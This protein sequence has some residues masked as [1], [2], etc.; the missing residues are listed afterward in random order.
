MTAARLALA[1]GLLTFAC[2][3]HGQQ[4]ALDCSQIKSTLIPFELST[5][6]KKID[7]AGQ[8]NSLGVAQVYRNT[9]G[10]TVI[11][12]KSQD[13][14]VSKL[15]RH[16]LFALTSTSSSQSIE[17]K[18][19][20]IDLNNFSMTENHTY[21]T[22]QIWNRIERTRLTAKY[23]YISTDI[24]EV[25]GC[26]FTV[27][28][29]R[30][31]AYGGSSPLASEELEYSPELQVSLYRKFNDFKLD[32]ARVELISVAKALRTTFIPLDVEQRK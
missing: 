32:E 12:G 25:S 13:N 20:G 29:L 4:Q 24:K 5:D 21:Y 16:G 31:T 8:A 26:S 3:A 17:Y 23:E 2:E 28:H 27:I 11:Y 22:W 1:L 19:D 30:N 7:A 10:E 14:P 9:S 18:Y 6:L 15:T